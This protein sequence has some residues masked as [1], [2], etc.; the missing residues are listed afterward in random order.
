M[1][2]LVA[3]LKA[4]P[5]KQL[6]LALQHLQRISYLN[7]IISKGITSASS[8]LSNTVNQAIVDFK[9]SKLTTAE[10]EII[11]RQDLRE[12]AKQKPATWPEDNKADIAAYKA[13]KAKVV[14]TQDDISFVVNA[15]AQ[16]EEKSDLAKTE[17]LSQDILVIGE[18][19]L[20]L[21]EMINKKEEISPEEAAL[22]MQELLPDQ[23]VLAGITSKLELLQDIFFEYN[24]VCNTP[25][26]NDRRG[27][28]H[29][30]VTTA[31]VQAKHKNNPEQHI[32]SKGEENQVPLSEKKLKQH[33]SR[34]RVD[35][36]EW[37]EIQDKIA[38]CEEY[39]K[40]KENEI[41]AS[42]LEAGVNVYEKYQRLLDDDNKTNIVRNVIKSYKNKN[43]DP[44]TKKFIAKHSQLIEALD[45]YKIIDDAQAILKNDKISRAERKANYEALLKPKET[46]KTIRKCRDT[47]FKTLLKTIGALVTG[48]VI[49]AP[50]TAHYLFFKS[51]G[52]KLLDNNTLSSDKKVHRKSIRI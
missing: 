47:V 4:I 41:I 21:Y 6:E 5:A 17:L 48:L 19:L 44:F 3:K 20:Q 39:K 25:D 1:K 37:A 31:V 22:V 36:D 7:E 2:R 29:Y 8:N 9:A 34:V 42:L 23:P 14:V 11:K 45:K 26:P 16:Q 52:D 13:V 51:K 10:L 43:D 12:L 15:L 28:I 30:S 24:G 33:A 32:E 27:R 50:L 38:E 40:D 18:H 46:Q 35:F 49:F